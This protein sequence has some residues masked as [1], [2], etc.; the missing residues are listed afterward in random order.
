M[1]NSFSTSTGERLVF[2]GLLLQWSV[3]RLSCSD[4]IFGPM[5]AIKGKKTL[6]SKHSASISM[7]NM[8]LHILLTLVIDLVLHNKNRTCRNSKIKIAMFTTTPHKC[9]GVN[10][11]CLSSIISDFIW[12]AWQVNSQW[13]YRLWT[14]VNS[15]C[16]N[17]IISSFICTAWKVNSQWKYRL[18]TIL[19]QLK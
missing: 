14:I 1:K 7:L 19:C 4:L 13:K 15:F 9:W 6:T 5:R 17:F 16:L 2:G 12:T 10:S 18:C 8:S 11:F 3:V